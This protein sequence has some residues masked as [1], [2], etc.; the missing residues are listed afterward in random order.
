MVGAA[1]KSAPNTGGKQFFVVMREQPTMKGQYT[2]L[3]EVTSGMEVVDQI[4]LTPV[5]GAE[6]DRARRDEGDDPRAA[7]RRGARACA[8][9]V[10]PTRSGCDLR[11]V[12]D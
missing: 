6:G 11:A 4:S 7:G 10:A 12:L 2:I 5:N 8:G 1:R 9:A 3:G